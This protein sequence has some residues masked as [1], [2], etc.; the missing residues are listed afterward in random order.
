MITIVDMFRKAVAPDTELV[1][2]P[3]RIR[4]EGIVPSNDFDVIWDLNDNTL[5]AYDL[6]VKLRH[7]SDVDINSLPPLLD[8]T[9]NSNSNPAEYWL[10]DYW[11]TL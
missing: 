6:V 11:V 2:L 10:H 1:F 5:V 3:V 7:I 4:P 9:P 8:G